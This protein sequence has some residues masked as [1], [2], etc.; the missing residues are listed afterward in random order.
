MDKSITTQPNYNDVVAQR[1]VE[2]IEKLLPPATRGK[3]SEA[4]FT[5]VFWPYLSGAV[6]PEPDNPVMNNWASVA[7]S[8]FNEVDVISND[9]DSSDLESAPVLFVVPAIQSTSHIDPTGGSGERIDAFISRYDQEIQV[10]PQMA[11]LKL[12]EK[13]NARMK[14]KA[15]YPVDFVRRVQMWYAIFNHYK[16]P[17]PQ[18]YLFEGI[19]VT[20]NYGVTNGGN[21]SIGY[22]SE[23]IDELEPED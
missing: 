2:Y 23:F 19:P 14:D 15:R 4:Y 22:T 13:F 17:I 10:S 12:Q 20:S 16:Q 1:G 18:H 5:S 7:G 21:T 6:T 3:I 8:L 11:I 9:Y